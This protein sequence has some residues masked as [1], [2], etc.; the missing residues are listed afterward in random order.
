MQNIQPGHTNRQRG[1]FACT[2]TDAFSGWEENDYGF[3][4]V[5]HA[6][7]GPFLVLSTSECSKRSADRAIATIGEIGSAEEEG[8]RTS[9]HIAGVTAPK[10]HSPAGQD[11]VAALAAGGRIGEAT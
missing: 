8:L 2:F 6:P 1:R 10:R 7:D 4:T 9:S 3:Q 5:L 11:E